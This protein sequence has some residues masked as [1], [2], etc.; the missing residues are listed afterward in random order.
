M[1]E[2]RGERRAETAK[3]N[4]DSELIEAAQKEA[5]GAAEHQ[6]GAEGGN[7]QRDVGKQ[8]EEQRATDPDATESITKS[9]HINHGHGESPPHPPTKV[10]TERD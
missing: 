8:A 10:V 6:A 7:L 4:D 5:R 9:D 2:S 3:E 1:T